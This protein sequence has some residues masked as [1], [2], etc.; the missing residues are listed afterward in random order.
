MKKHNNNNNK[1][2]YAHTHVYRSEFMDN[3]AS[4][5][6]ISNDRWDKENIRCTFYSDIVLGQ[7]SEISV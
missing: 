3:R 1:E 2:I 7:G 4:V 6:E 5:K